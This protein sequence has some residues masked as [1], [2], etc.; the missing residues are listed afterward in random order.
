MELLK[1]LKLRNPKAMY[2]K[3]NVSERKPTLLLLNPPSNCFVHRS[4]KIWNILAPKLGIS[5]YSVKINTTK[6]ILKQ[7]L[8][9]RQHVEEIIEWTLEDH[10]IA[11][12]V[13]KTSTCLS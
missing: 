4:A 11:K 3:F 8:L 10:N 2:A 13:V 5:D 7:A 9:K 6:N 12:V 1:V